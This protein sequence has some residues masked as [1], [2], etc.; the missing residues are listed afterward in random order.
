[1]ALSEYKDVYRLDSLIPRVNDIASALDTQHGEKYIQRYK[2]E[3][4][5][6]IKK[7]KDRIKCLY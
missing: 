4:K 7:F 2:N 5:E 1:M 3:L 6:L